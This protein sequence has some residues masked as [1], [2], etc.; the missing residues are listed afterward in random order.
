MVSGSM[1]R[2]RGTTC[3]VCGEKLGTEPTVALQGHL[4]GSQRCVAIRVHQ[5]CATLLA[6]S[7][8]ASLHATRE[9]PPPLPRATPA[10]KIGLTA[11]E[12]RILQKIV[13]GMTNREI[14]RE[15]GLAPKTVKN[16][17]STVLYKLEVAS[18]TEAAVVAVMT[19]LIET[20]T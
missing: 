3:F 12:Q 2:G 13:A 11:A 9:N 15:L 7:V 17:V 20:G 19:G 10:E 16:A 14:A 18:R 8:L 6:E 5:H 1:Q 4:Q